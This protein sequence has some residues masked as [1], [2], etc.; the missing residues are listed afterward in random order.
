MRYSLSKAFKTI[1]LLPGKIR[2][3]DVWTAK[4]LSFDG[5]TTQQG[6]GWGRC[7]KC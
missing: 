4:T 7:C 1:E 2:F 5:E 3:M 6:A